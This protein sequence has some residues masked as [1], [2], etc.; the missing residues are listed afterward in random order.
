MRGDEHRKHATRM[1]RKQRGGF[2]GQRPQPYATDTYWVAGEEEAPRVMTAEDIERKR[3]ED[4]K[5]V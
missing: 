4:D 5:A 2:Y 3:T 1:H